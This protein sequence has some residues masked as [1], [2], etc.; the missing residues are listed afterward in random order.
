MFAID[1]PTSLPAALVPGLDEE[2]RTIATVVVKATFRLREGELA[3]ADEQVPLHDVDEHHGDP[4]TSSVRYEADRSPQKAGTDIVLIGHAWSPAPTPELDV[5]LVAGPVR[6]TLRVFGDRA[7]F[8]SGH[9]FGISDPHPFTR[10]PL[11]YERAF[12]GADGEAFDARNPVGIGFHA[13]LDQADGARLPN[14]EDPRSLI[15]HPEDRP[16]PAGFGFVARHW[17]PRRAFAGTY[18]AAWRADRCPLLPRDFD[19]RF[20]QAAPPELVSPRLFQGGEPV[21]IEGAS[22]RGPVAFRVPRPAL[23]IA[24]S[25]KRSV[26]HHRPV[27]DTIVIEPDERRVVLTHRLTFPCPRNYLP[28]DGVR[29]AMKREAA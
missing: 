19:R 24:V 1:N 17:A 25:I 27:I 2:G 28:L 15:R 21:R 9:E 23:E 22:E 18:D 8:Q 26:T 7:F 16:V 29:I 12:G 6:K 20:L 3:L 10:V 11:V 13:S 5:S 14:I 4:A